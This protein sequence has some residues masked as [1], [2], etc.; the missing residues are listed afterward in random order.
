MYSS[1]VFHGTVGREKDESIV[2]H[3]LMRVAVYMK[4]TNQS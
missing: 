3:A 2:F 1:P 4:Q